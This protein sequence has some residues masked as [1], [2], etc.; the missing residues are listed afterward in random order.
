MKYLVIMPALNEEDLI[1]H[2]IEDIKQS[3]SFADI[4]VVNDGSTD[5]TAQ[6]ARDKGAI[7]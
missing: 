5:K 4:V 2:V 3:L 1:G 7:V 6:I